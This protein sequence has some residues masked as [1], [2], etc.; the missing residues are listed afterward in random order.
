MASFRIERV[1]AVPGTLTANTIYI[2]SVAADRAEIYITGN[3]ATARRILNETDVEALIDAAVSGLAGVQV[4]ANIAERDA[5]VLTSNAQVFVIDATGD[6]TVASGGAT[7]VY[8]ASNDTFTKISEAESLDLV[9]Q[10]A[11]IQ[12]KPTSSAAA[13]DAAV[14]ASHSHSNKTQ[15]DQIGQNAD[16]D[17]TYNGREYVRSGAAD[18]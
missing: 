14:T 15:L 5:L 3:T 6:A 12:G 13:I 4:V 17:F 11:A 7:Y 9:L 16:G 1:T 18:W 8:R 2:V 10:W